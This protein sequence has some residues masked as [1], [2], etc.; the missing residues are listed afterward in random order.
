MRNDFK[1]G[2]SK[3]VL[4][5][6]IFLFLISFTSAAVDTNT[7]DDTFQVNALIPYAKGCMNN[8]TYCSAAATCNFTFYDLDNSL[9]ENNVP[10]INIGDGSSTWT[11]N[12]TYSK[13]G[14]YQVDMVCIDGG[15]A[16]FE[17]FYSQVTG[18][19]LNDNF[20][21][22]VIVIGLSLGVIIIGFNMEDPIITIFGSFGLY[23]LGLYILFNGIAGVKDLVTTWAIGII[24]L[25]I[26]A[27]VSIRSAHE[28]ITG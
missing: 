19:G 2:R 1:L 26:A 12:I 20:W 3:F 14:V 9:L 24:M 18:S 23:F 10:G 27:Y 15:E 4:F 7:V 22:Y 8:G 11:Y 25:G 21:F 17:T 16:G 28:L 5:L 6:P 13:T